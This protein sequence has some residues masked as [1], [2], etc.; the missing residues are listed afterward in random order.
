MK[1][2]PTSTPS[3]SRPVARSCGRP[4]AGPSA[5]RGNIRSNQSS[6][7]MVRAGRSSVGATAEAV[8]PIS[9]PS[10]SR[11]VAQSSGRPTA[12]PSAPP[13]GTSPTLQSSQTAQAGPS[14][15]GTTI[16]AAPASTSTRSESHPVVRSCGRPT[17]WPSAPP[18]TLSC[19]PP[20]PLTARAGPSSPGRTTV[21]AAPAT[22]TPNGSRAVA[23][24]SGRPLAWPSVRPPPIRCTPPPSRAARA[25]P[26][27][28]GR[29]TAAAKVT[30]SLSG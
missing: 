12:F 25:G 23:R 8:A 13:P 9:T 22:S 20:S 11:P 4:T 1:R 16:A 28:P 5:P 18:P 17:A 7:P 30:S 24:S 3:G 19:T 6:P 2:T 27:S 10:G 29:T 26:S 14:S 21:A 15:P